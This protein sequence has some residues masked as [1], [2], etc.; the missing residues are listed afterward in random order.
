MSGAAPY[1]SLANEISML[2]FDDLVLLQIATVMHLA[3]YS[4]KHKPV[5]NLNRSAGW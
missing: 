2:K 5:I 4:P 3:T 1:E